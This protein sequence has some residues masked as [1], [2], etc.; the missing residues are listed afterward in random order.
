[1]FLSAPTLAICFIGFNPS[2]FAHR[3]RVRAAATDG[4]MR[5]PSSYFVIPS[6]VT[7]LNVFLFNPIVGHGEG[8][9]FHSVVSAMSVCKINRWLVNLLM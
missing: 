3:N 2:T 4:N 1:M 8:R 5:R 9:S 7:G 6:F